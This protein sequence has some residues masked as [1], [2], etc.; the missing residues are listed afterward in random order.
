L[1]WIAAWPGGALL[2]VANGIAREKV[3][4]PRTGELA[5][6][7]IS[8]GTLIAALGA[9]FAALDRRWPLRTRGQALRAGAGWLA[10]TT[11][12]EF[13]FGHWVADEPWDALLADYDLAHGRL[14]GLVLA[15]TALGPLTVAQARR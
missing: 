13:G 15:W 8:T 7:Q 10:L 2:G 9:Y 11:L 4:A 5:A 3:Y 14:W 6:H 12:F 1:R